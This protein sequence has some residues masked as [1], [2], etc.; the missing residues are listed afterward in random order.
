[1]RY[2]LALAR[3]RRVLATAAAKGEVPAKLFDQA[4]RRET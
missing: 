3:L 1:M 4:L 2:Q